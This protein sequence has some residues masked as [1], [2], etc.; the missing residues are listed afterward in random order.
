VTAVEDGLN[1][2]LTATVTAKGKPVE[3]ALVNFTESTTMFAPG[4]N[5]VPLGSVE[6]DKS[7]TAVVTYVAAVTGPRTI[8]A[9]YFPT[10]MSD[11]VVGTAGLD[12]TQAANRYRPPPEKALTGV[13]HTLVLALFGLVLLVLGLLTVQVVRVRRAC[14]PATNGL[15]SQ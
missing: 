11:A 7:G 12:V 4:D 14:R 9:T 5:Q 3:G 6:T 10:V 15:P 1:I 2:T 13:G 8:T